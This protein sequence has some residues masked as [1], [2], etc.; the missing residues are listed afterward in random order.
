MLGR[1][2]LQTRRRRAVTRQQR[3]DVVGA[4]VTSLRHDRQ[5]RRS[6]A[7]I[8]GGRRRGVRIGRRELVGGGGVAHQRLA[9]LAVD[10]RDLNFLGQSLHDRVVVRVRVFRVP[11]RPVLVAQ[12]TEVHQ[13]HAVARG[14]D[15]LVDLVAALQ[16]ALV[17]GAER[18]L[19]AEAAATRMLGA[20]SGQ[21]RSGGGGQAQGGRQN[22]QGLA[23]GH[24]FLLVGN[25][26]A[27][28]FCSASP[29]R[30]GS[31]IVA[32]TGSGFSRRPRNGIS[33]RK[34][35]K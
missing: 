29:D 35:M 34:K 32:G 20:P 9:R 33:T 24:G 30:T 2:H 23:E 28:P 21:R 5:V 4:V 3:V 10:V 17:I 25:H 7:A 26:R 12:V 19:E 13:L 18:P 27:Q 15:F 14:A 6:R 31:E 22:D 1:G 8:G 16:L 11:E